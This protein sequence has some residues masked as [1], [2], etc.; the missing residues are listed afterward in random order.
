MVALQLVEKLNRLGV[1]ALLQRL[2]AGSV[3]TFGR[4]IDCGI[5][6]C[7]AAGQAGK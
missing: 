3:K 7:P 5:G 1:T 4:A 2:N 6:P